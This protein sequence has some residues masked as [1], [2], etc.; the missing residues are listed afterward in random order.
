MDINTSIEYVQGV[1]PKKSATLIS[2]IGVRTVGD[3][4]T[5]YPYRYVD[6]TK[7]Y[8]INEC[9]AENAYVQICG[10]IVSYDELGEGRNRRLVAKFIDQ[11]GM[12]D[13][14]WFSK[15]RYVE[16]RI[17]LNTKYIVFGKPTI[18]GKR[19][20]IVH[21]ELETYDEHT[22]SKLIGLQPLYNTTEKMKSGFLASNGFRKIIFSILENK[23]LNIPETLPKWLLDRYGLLDRQTAIYQIHRPENSEL[24]R[25]AQNRLKFEELFYIQLSIMRQ[26]KMRQL[27]YQGFIFSKIGDYFNRFYHNFLPFALT[28]AQKRVMREI[29]ADMATGKQMNRL[30][31]GDVGSGKTMIALLSSLIALDN[32]Y[33]ACIMAPTEILA[34]Q[35][36]VSISEQLFPLGI[37]VQ[38]LTGSVT[39]KKRREILQ[40][41]IDGSLHLIV[42]THALIED[43]VEFKNLGLVVIDEQHRFGVAQRA[44][45]W[46]KNTC[47]PHILVMTATP[48]PR[49]LAMTIYGD[50]DVSI[51]DELPPGRKPI[52]TYHYYDN[53]RTG[54]YQFIRKQLELGHQAYIVYPLINENEKMDLKNLMDGYTTISELFPD[55]RVV[56][57]HGKMKAAEKEHAMQLFVSGNAHIMVATTV[58]EV[59]VNVPNANVMVIES[60]ERFGLSQLH[61]LRG[62]VGRGAEQSY[63]ILMSKVELSND[64]QK[65]LSIMCESTDG[66]VI[67]E[68]DLQLRGPGDIEG[69]QQS[70]LPFNL[71][72]ANLA[73]DGKT[74]QDARNLAKDILDEDPLLSSE[75]NIV[76]KQVLENMKNGNVNWGVIS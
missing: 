43:N 29:R 66:F 45:L 21:P 69:L 34:T 60:A 31:Q 63:C 27:K 32:G 52:A 53:R 30:L 38:L 44:K 70:G 71:K 36:Y 74:L 48:I 62:R 25:K 26:S 19:V 75:K 35:H 2:E 12:L 23:Q 5:Y 58:I 54:L 18:F 28:N 10:I 14:V 59:G 9:V 67:A 40:S 46:K 64:T 24:L 55:Y 65:R 49:T 37:N 42:G 61:Q 73:T 47:P 8:K 39:A 3:A 7:F 6:R 1:G 11:T 68:A 56:M 51:I 72:I 16:E 4:L 17:R 33:Q 20:S 57:V 50:L 41:L 22:V 13:L 76:I 15:L